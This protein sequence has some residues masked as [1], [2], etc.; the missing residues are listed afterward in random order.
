MPQ[1]PTSIPTDNS[2]S[3]SHIEF[4][5]NYTEMPQSPTSTPTA[6]IPSA[7]HRELENNYTEMPQSPTSI[8]TTLATDI[9]TDF[10]RR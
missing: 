1:S 8:P 4:E 2:P 7:S 5:N 10:V 6:S 9:P 3:A